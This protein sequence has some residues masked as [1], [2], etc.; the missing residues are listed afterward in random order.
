MTSQEPILARKF[1]VALTG[2]IGSGKSAVAAIFSKLGVYVVDTDEISHELTSTGGK[3]V[4]KIAEV[5]GPEYISRG[6]LDRAKMRELVF[7][8]AASRKNLEAILHPMIRHEVEKGVAT[9]DSPYCLI[10]VPL[11]FETRSY[12]DLADRILV[13]DC[14]E[15]LQVVR[16]MARSSLTRDE[17]QAIMKS[18]ADRS[19]RL[20]GADDILLNEGSLEELESSVLLLHDRYLAKCLKN[21]S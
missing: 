4:G 14:N 12:H 20:S 17:V 13:V 1:C 6:K 2:G 9:C 18:Q 19:V 3:A 7:S 8:D 11:L 5:F 15:H 10:V 21:P 16:A